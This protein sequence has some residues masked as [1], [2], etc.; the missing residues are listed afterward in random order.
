MPT[1]PEADYPEEGGR[2]ALSEMSFFGHLEELRKRIVWAL[3]GLII[4]S[5]A[6]G[7]FAQQIMDYILLRPAIIAK[8]ELQN[9]RP[10]GQAFLFFKVILVSGV[11]IS[12]PFT[13]YQIWKFVAPGLHEHERNWAGKITGFT[14]LCFLCGVAFAYWVMIPT[15]LEFSANFGTTSIK[16]IIDITEYFGFITTTVLGS[17]LI[18]ELPMISYVL[19]RVGILTPQ[20]MKQHRR[21]AIVVIL[22]IAA[23]L[24]PSPDPVNQLIFAAPLWVLFEISII[25]SKFAVKKKAEVAA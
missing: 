10:F 1:E 14:T 7:F 23:V 13:L 12:M 20:W 11:V 8:V 25:I 22:V 15:M 9:L 24:T 5:V 4:A 6:A 18:F 2:P 19:T 16:N 3:L 17:G 21:H